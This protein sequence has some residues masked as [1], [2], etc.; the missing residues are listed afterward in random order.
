[1][2][3]L[4]PLGDG[5]RSLSQPQWPNGWPRQ[6]TQQHSHAHNRTPS[7]ITTSHSPLSQPKRKYIHVPI[8]PKSNATPNTKSLFFI[9]ANKFSAMLYFP[10]IHH[11]YLLRHIQIIS[12]NHTSY[13]VSMFHDPFSFLFLSCTINEYPHTHRHMSLSLSLA[14]S[15]SYV[16]QN[17]ARFQSAIQLYIIYRTTK[18]EHFKVEWI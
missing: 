5:R 14:R 12:H 13:S 16:D 7:R 6:T 1:M 4:K 10:M 8:H 9:H 3:I 2:I 11:F 17:S 18:R 15:P